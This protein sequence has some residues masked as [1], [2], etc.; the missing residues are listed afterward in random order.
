[1]IS[2]LELARMGSIGRAFQ[3]DMSDIFNTMVDE[4]RPV[5]KSPN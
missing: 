5:A 3:K 4:T 1:M 2:Y